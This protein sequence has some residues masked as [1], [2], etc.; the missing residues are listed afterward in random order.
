M[1]SRRTLLTGAGAFAALPFLP[2][3]GRA[4]TGV[5]RLEMPQ[6]LDAVESGRFALQAQAGTVN[7]L[8][9]ADS[10]TWGFNQPFLGPTLRLRNSNDTQAQVENALDEAIS[11][12]WHG[13]VAPGHVDGGPHQTIAS[14]DVWSPVLPVNQPAATIWYHSHTHGETGRQVN[15]GLAGVIH[16]TDGQDDARGLPSTYGVDDLT[17]VLQDRFFD[18]SG[19]MIYS[20]SMHD[21]MMGFMGNTMLVN[22]QAGATAI[23]PQG[24]VRL[25]LLNGSNARFYGLRLSDNRSMH[26]IG[27]DSGLLDR[28]IALDFLTIAPGERYEVLVDFG[29]GQDVSLISEQALNADLSGGQPGA[30]PFEILP[31]AVDTSMPARIL[32]VPDAI[33]GTLP[34]LD[35]TAVNRREIALEM[36]MGPMAM[37]SN[38]PH[39]INGRSFDMQ[40]TNFTISQGTLERWVVSGTMMMHP[41]HVHG[42][43]FQ[44][45]SENDAAPRVQNRGWKDTVVING[46]AEILMAFDQQAGAE[47]PFMFHCHILE[48]EDGGMMGQFAVA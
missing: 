1:V 43:K 27:T 31:F 28:S 13:L 47:L 20:L 42:V 22:G 8:G 41:F 33:G 7:F 40:R 6:L 11:V 12:H 18:Q 36:G 46:Q 14:G 16:L 32:A 26:L 9:H 2:G 19:R 38:S 30:T 24:I 23:V 5:K 39:A 35:V 37:M 21:R 4:Q 10:V 34:Q 17:L 44:V 15:N 29:D 25:R 45:L 48:H 3:L